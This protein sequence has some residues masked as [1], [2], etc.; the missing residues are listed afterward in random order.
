M[1]EFFSSPADRLLADLRQ[2]QQLMNLIIKGCIEHRWAL[3]DEEKEIAKAIIYNAFETY[4]IAR[5]MA[6]P[7]AEQFCEQYLERLIQ[8]VQE[9]L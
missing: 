3:S 6:L 5:G 8:Q 7:E 2:E 1:T 4:A 9:I